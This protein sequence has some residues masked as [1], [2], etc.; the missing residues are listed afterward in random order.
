MNVY[1]PTCDANIFVIKYFQYFFNKYW[2]DNT[3][4][5]ILGFNPPNFKLDKNFEFISL[6][7]KQENGAKGWSNYLIDFFET[8]DD[9]FFIFG[10]DDFMVARPVDRKLLEMCKKEIMTDD[11]IGRVDLQCSLQYARSRKDVS[12]HKIVDG[13]GFLKLKQSGHGRDIYRVGGAFSIW[14][15]SWFL[16]NMKRDWSPW[17]WELKGSKLSENDGYEVIGTF[18]RWAVKKVEMLSGHWG[19]IMNVRALREEDI[20][21]MKE[22]VDDKDR[23]TTFHKIMDDKWGY[24]VLGNRWVEVI[25]GE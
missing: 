21:K 3:N 12:P 7:D 19:D 20:Q 8:I 11:S 10:I 24:E 15:K 23:V 13:V 17:D 16:K 6:G 4:V 5:K 9:E 14:R 25:Y 22:M 1:I 18:N 2:D